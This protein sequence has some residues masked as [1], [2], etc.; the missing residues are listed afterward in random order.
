M[1]SLRG[2]FEYIF[3]CRRFY[4]ACIYLNNLYLYHILCTVFL[5]WK[6]LSM[7]FVIFCR[8]WRLVLKIV[9]T[10]SMSFLPRRNFLMKLLKYWVQR[11]EFILM[12]LYTQLFIAYNISW[13]LCSC[14]DFKSI[15]L[16]YF[17]LL[18]LQLVT[19]NVL[20]VHMDMKE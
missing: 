1:R 18:S 9:D 15:Q 12:V 19:L 10:D 14:C 5:K 13:V 8:C 16:E 7:Y 3:E 2:S 4:S 6:K 11:W 20:P 17:I